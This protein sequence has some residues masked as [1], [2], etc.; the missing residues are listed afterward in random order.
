M[1]LNLVVVNAGKASGQ[2]IS[3]K[4][5]QFVI[6]RDPQCNLRPSSAM[7]SK[8]HC[9]LIINDETVLLRDFE[10][11]NGTF[12]NDEPVKGEVQLKNNDVLKVG[13]LVFRVVMEPTMA[14]T[15]PTP[16][17]KPVQVTKS[18][19]DDEAAALLLSLEGGSIAPADST[20][21]KEVPGGSTVMDIPSFAAPAA[22]SD[23]KP[24]KP[25]DKKKE[26][27]AKHDSASQAAAALIDKM[28]KGVR[29]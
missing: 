14:P 10:S 18:T 25:D 26:D 20:S 7:I 4:I 5:P 3:I 8:R 28:R 23:Q 2:T 21:D 27:K 22:E 1:K 16:A 24:A 29:K 15:K 17:P 12:V 6:G 11:T 19:E 9:A 13:P